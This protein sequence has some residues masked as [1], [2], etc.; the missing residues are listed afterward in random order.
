MFK[1]LYA[2]LAIALVVLLSLI[3]IFYILLTLYSTRLYLQE[4]DQKFN[5]TLAANLLADKDLMTGDRVNDAV[6]QEIF[7]MYMV[8]NPNIEIYLLDERGTILAFSAPPGK[9]KRNKVSLEPVRKFLSSPDRLP[10]LGSD[11]RSLDRKKVF[12]VAPVVS[13]GRTQGY[14]YVVLGGEDYHSVAR[15]LEGSYVLRLSTWTVVA[16]LLLGLVAG[17]VLFNFLTRRLARLSA[18]MKAFQENDLTELDITQEL[19]ASSGDEIS[20]LGATFK[21]MAERLAQQMHALKKTDRLRRELVANV[22]H[23]LRTPIASLQGYLET[24]L[25]KEGKLSA[26]EQRKYLKIAMRHSEQLAKLVAELFELAKLDSQEIQLQREPFALAELVQDMLLNFQ[27]VSENTGV[28]LEPDIPKDLPLVSGDIALIERVLENLMENAFRHTP[29]GGAVKIIVCL[30]ENVVVVYVTDNGCG[31][32]PDDLAHIFDRFY[33]VRRNARERTTGA[34]LGLAIAK[35]ILDL[36]GTPIEV[37]SE[38]NVGTTFQFSLPVSS[39]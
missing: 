20:Q 6:L 27:L 28:K 37:Q 29:Q 17:L 11:P 9:V 23:D 10:I 5:R 31:I 16:S 24:L 26:V 36:H 34:G 30:E 13:E 33:Q 8:I 7:H 19:D 4:V 15:L 32:A 14:L 12:S 21:E 38:L 1:T 35:R 18:A 3:A 2:K 25:L 22:S 39:A